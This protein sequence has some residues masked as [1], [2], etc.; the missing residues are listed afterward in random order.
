MGRS[1]AVASRRERAG[2]EEREREDENN[3]Y[4]FKIGKSIVITGG[5]SSISQPAADAL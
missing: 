4:K 5:P 2:V 1:V 3:S